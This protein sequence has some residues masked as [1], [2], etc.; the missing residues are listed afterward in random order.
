MDEELHDLKTRLLQSIFRIKQ[1]VSI[2]HYCA[3]AQAAMHELSIAEFTLLKAI[4]NN[5]MDS[6]EN[7][8][9]S[10]ITEHLYITKAA[11]SKML[12]VL[13]NKGYVNRDI[14]RRNRRELTITLTPL[15][16]EVIIHYEK[17]FDDMLTG[18]IRQLGKNDV[19]QF[20]KNINQFADAANNIVR[21][22][23][24]GVTRDAANN[25]VKEATSGGVRNATNSV[26]IEAANGIVKDTP[27][28]IASETAK[29]R[30]NR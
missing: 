2:F 8:G 27:S 3:D 16:K 18:I 24:G 29:G 11:V 14:S 10:Y 28:G 15:G 30:Y 13:E 21:D 25:D 9:V 23:A 19:E 12:G 4:M 26:T 22:A 6:D 17:Y 1:L 7:I 20:T 5:A